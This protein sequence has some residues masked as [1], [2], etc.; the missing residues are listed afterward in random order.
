MPAQVPGQPV[1]PA[2]Q[3]ETKSFTERDEKWFKIKQ[4]YIINGSS[5]P[6]K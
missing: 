5:V 4:Y 2:P 1:M 6:I 3:Q